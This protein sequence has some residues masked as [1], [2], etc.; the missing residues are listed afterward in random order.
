MLPTWVPDWRSWFYALDL[1]ME[2]ATSHFAQAECKF[3][4]HGI[5]QVL[6][7]YAVEVHEVQSL[8]ISDAHQHNLKW[9]R[10]LISLMTGP[11]EPV[12]LELAVERFNYAICCGLNNLRID[13]TI[14]HEYRKAIRS[15]VQY[16]Y[17]E[18]RRPDTE[19]TAPLDM[20][21][22]P[23]AWALEYCVGLLKQSQLP[24][25]S[26]E[27]GFVGIGPQKARQGDIVTAI[28]GCRALMLLRPVGTD[29]YQVV[30]PCFVHGFNWGEALLGPL[31]KNYAVVPQLD[32]SR[33]VYMPHY[34]NTDTG[35]SSLW[36]P[37]IA[38]EELLA[39]PPMVNFSLIPAHPEEPMRIRPDSDYL[40]R[41]GVNLQRF[42]LE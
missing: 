13:L 24:F 26:C 16:L 15:Y 25:V 38:W 32:P 20:I 40:K 35:V 11:E 30:G 36:D 6:G 42:L 37:R 33:N 14:A 29:R 1:S 17:I 8:D 41:H 39:H 21:G 34:L 2:S 9:F 22:E 18:R 12:D 4:D 5:L 19:L 3:L 10:E 7:C 27:H 31:P 23:A 28:L